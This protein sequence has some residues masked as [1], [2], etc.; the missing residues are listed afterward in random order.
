[1]LVIIQIDD[2]IGAWAVEYMIAEQDE[3]TFLRIQVTDL[4]HTCAELWACMLMLIFSVWTSLFYYLLANFKH[5]SD[6]H[7]FV[8]TL[9]SYAFFFVWPIFQMIF[10]CFSVCCG[11]FKEDPE[12][13]DDY[14]RMEEMKED[15]GHRHC[16]DHNAEF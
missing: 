8:Y 11:C 7:F 13:A 9:Y 14:E 3:A 6:S 1:L 16:H 15:P 10:K 12:K 2:F 4:E 5:D